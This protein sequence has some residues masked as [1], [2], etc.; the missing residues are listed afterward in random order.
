MGA[1]QQEITKIVPIRQMTMSTG[2]DL[3]EDD[4]DSNALPTPLTF[5]DGELVYAWARVD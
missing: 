1:T 2:D 3:D 5:W 4:I